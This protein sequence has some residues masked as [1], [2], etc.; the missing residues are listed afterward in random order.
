MSDEKIYPVPADFAANALINAEQYDALYKQ[1]LED[2]DGFWA[3][4]AEIFLTWSKKWDKVQEWDFHTAEIK[5][6][7]GGKLNAAY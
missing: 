5:W 3:E 7:E 1:S 4:Q 2:T 6:F